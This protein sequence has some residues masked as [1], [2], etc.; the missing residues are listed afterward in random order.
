MKKKKGTLL[1]ARGGVLGFYAGKKTKKKIYYC[2]L[3]G[4]L[5][6]KFQ[7]E[8]KHSK[9]KE[10]LN[11]SKHRVQVRKSLNKK[12]YKIKKNRLRFLLG[13]KILL[14]PR[15]N[16]FSHPKFFSKFFREIDKHNITKNWTNKPDFNIS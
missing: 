13:K 11:Y 15:L 12:K 2:F 4:W 3:K 10:R 9:K 14:M 1:G 8:K 7:E 5:W 16:N 6:L